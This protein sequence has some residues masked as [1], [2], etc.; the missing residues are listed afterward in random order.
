MTSITEP[1][2]PRWPPEPQSL[3]SQLIALHPQ[4]HASALPYAERGRTDADWIIGVK[5]VTDGA[6]VHAGQWERHPGGEEVLALLEGSVRVILAGDDGQGG[7]H[8]VPLSAGQMLV[9]PRGTWH[10]LQVVQPGRLMF[11]TPSRGSEHRRVQ[12]LDVIGA[13]P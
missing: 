2:N 13:A 5:T 12:P 10:R 4:A 7:E 9:V 1:L 8:A 6:S 11:V 3:A